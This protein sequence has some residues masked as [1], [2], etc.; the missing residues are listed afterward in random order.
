M[1]HA[2]RLILRERLLD[3]VALRVRVEATVRVGVVEVERLRLRMAVSVNDLEAAG[4]EEERVPVEDTCE[5][6][7]LAGREGVIDGLITRLADAERKA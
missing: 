5:G 2:R 3:L 6:E 1:A 4:L 7:L